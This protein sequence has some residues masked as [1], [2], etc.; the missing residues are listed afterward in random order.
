M[1]IIQINARYFSMQEQLQQYL[2]EQDP[3]IVFLQ[4]V[5]D[6]LLSRGVTDYPLDD[7]AKNL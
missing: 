6:G 4:E 7:I 1:K 3:D 5:A 2:L